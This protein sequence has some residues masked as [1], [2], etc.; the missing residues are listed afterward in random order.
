ML[1]WLQKLRY[2]FHS[3]NKN[4]SGSYIGHQP[5]VIRGKGSVSFGNDVS[6]GVINS[7]MFLNSYA[8]IEPRH[9][10]ANIIFGN[11]VNINN[12]CSFI[13]EKKITLGNDILIGFNCHISD[14][15]FHDLNPENRKNTDPD[16]QEVCIE[17]N[18]FIGNN[19]TILKGVTIGENAVVASGSVVTKSCESNVVIGGV[20]AK[21]IRSL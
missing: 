5:V 12:S 19:V 15:N 17:D 18:V 9:K 3:T 1:R 21:V 16:P 2:S 20:P 11:N 10:D 13:S 14:S 4:I 6:L 7:P 8:Y